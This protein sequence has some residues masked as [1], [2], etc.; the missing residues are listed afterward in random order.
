M[1]NRDLNSRCAVMRG[2]HL[3][4]LFAFSLLILTIFPLRF[5]YAEG[6]KTVVVKVSGGAVQYTTW[7]TQSDGSKVA[8]ET[9]ELKPGAT[10]PSDTTLYIP[11]GVTVTLTRDGE[12]VEL[13]GPVEYDVSSGEQSA[14]EEPGAGETGTS[15]TPQAGGGDFDEQIPSQTQSCPS[16]PC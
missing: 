13:V 11:E 8:K 6:G 3:K 5:L 14:Y 7:T 1:G 16:P 12:Q 15:A 4:G 2:I 10:L 9:G